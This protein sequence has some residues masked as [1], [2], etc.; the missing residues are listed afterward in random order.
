L[1]YNAIYG[2]P[3]PRRTRLTARIAPLQ[4]GI[5][6]VLLPLTKRRIRKQ[7]EGWMRPPEDLLLREHGERGWTR[8]AGPESTDETK[9]LLR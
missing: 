6:S 4:R 5:T 1:L 7:Y 2:Q 3:E 9:A 8:G